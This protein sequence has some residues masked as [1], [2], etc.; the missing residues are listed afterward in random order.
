[1]KLCENPQWH[2]PLYNHFEFGTVE[3]AM[4]VLFWRQKRPYLDENKEVGEDIL[5]GSDWEPEDIKRTPLHRVFYSK[6]EFDLQ[7]E[8]LA[9]LKKIW[10]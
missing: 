10:K 4:L 2:H 6:W 9:F 5:T 8:H 7:T 1:M 3:V